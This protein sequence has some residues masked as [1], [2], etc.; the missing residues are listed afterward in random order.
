MLGMLDGSDPLINSLE[1]PFI[2]FN[3]SVIGL[4][5]CKVIKSSKKGAC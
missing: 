3:S 5:K 1:Y 2:D 4:S